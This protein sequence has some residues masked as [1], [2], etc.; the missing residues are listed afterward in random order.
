MFVMN[1]D[2]PFQ[3]LWRTLH[4][5]YKITVLT[6]YIHIFDSLPKGGTSYIK[7]PK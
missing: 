7:T 6:R 3:Y 5:G 2:C 4:K 1:L